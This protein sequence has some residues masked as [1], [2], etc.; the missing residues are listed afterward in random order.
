VAAIGADQRRKDMNRRRLASAVRA[1]ESEHRTFGD[2]EIDAVQHDLLAVRLP[3]PG[4]VDGR[5]APHGRHDAPPIATAPS[6][7][8]SDVEILDRWPLRRAGDQ[9]EKL[10]RD[11]LTELVDRLEDVEGRLAGRGPVAD[12]ADAEVAAPAG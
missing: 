1:Q 10:G 5:P 7:P 12:V 2:V 6:G 4:R 3:Q 11:P 9:I 8:G